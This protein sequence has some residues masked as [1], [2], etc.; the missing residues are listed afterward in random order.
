MLSAHSVYPLPCSLNKT[1]LHIATQQEGI[2]KPR[3][4][5][6]LEVRVLKAFGA[7]PSQATQ[8]SLGEKRRHCQTVPHV[9]MCFLQLTWE[10]HLR[11]V[12]H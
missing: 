8:G 7:D 5:Q 3:L 2:H 1:L 9:G 10:I 12:M 4:D 6:L 11:N